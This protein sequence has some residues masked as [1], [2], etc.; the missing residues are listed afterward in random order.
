MRRMLAVVGVSLLCAS[1]F[2][3]LA[4]GLG[5]ITLHSALNQKLDAEIELIETGGLDPSEVMASLASAEDFNRVGVERFFYLTSLR[6][7]VTSRGGRMFIRVTSAQPVTEPYLNFL[8]QLLW[9][10]GRLLKEYTLLLDPPAFAEQSVAPAIAPPSRGDPGG[11]PAGRVERRPTRPDSQVSLAPSS[12]SRQAPENRLRDGSYGMT[13]R[14]DTLWT[15][16]LKT[17]PSS[18]VS[19]QQQMLA[20]QRANPEAFIGGNIN[21]LKAGFTLRLPSEEEAVAVTVADANAEVAE[22]TRQWQAFRSGEPLPT[23][24]GLGGASSMDRASAE[25]PQLAQQVDATTSSSTPAANTTGPDGELRIVAS[26]GGT[27]IGSG[28]DS[29]TEAGDVEGKLVASEEERDRIARENDELVY[30]VDRL[31]GDLEQAQRQVEVRDQQIAQLQQRLGELE[32][33]AGAQPAAAPAAKPTQLADWL[34]SPIVLIGVLVVVVGGI[35]WALIAARTRRARES[36]TADDVMPASRQTRVR[37]GR[38]TPIAPVAD[39]VADDPAEAP[40]E[41]VAEMTPNE[42]PADDEVVPGAQTS[43]VIGEAEI[44]IAYGRFPQAIGLLLAALDD[45]PGRSDVR[46]KLLELYTETRDEEGFALQ[47]AELV[48]RTDDD[49]V[50][51]E[52][53][54]LEAK[55]RDEDSARER[56]TPTADGAASEDTRGLDEFSLDLEDEPAAPREPTPRP[57]ANA[58]GGAG[59]ELGGDLGIDFDPDREPTM[60]R[61][62]RGNRPGRSAREDGADTAVEFDLE[63]LEL[64]SGGPA[65]T[66]DASKDESDDAFDFLDEEDAASTKLDLARAYIEMGDQDGARDILSEVL[67]EGTSEQQQAANELLEKLG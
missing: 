20:L 31:N 15:I 2:P 50:L 3:A 18:R 21:L 55:L 59:D 47:M 67:Q 56:S 52:A 54:A 33:Q 1:A 10:N 64:E 24:A 4:V 57:S 62:S 13:D 29:A 17:R 14:D 16:A 30:K 34:Q 49:A 19:V 66:T 32:K 60:L 41:P 22:H 38:A 43:D 65:T 63:D 11:G 27:G 5:E 6:F 28:G 48:E 61:A 26:E 25:E 12:D 46:L 40:S 44:Y 58:A 42:A 51:L 45:D 37:G 36:S 7:A 35:V 8:V 9:P 53:R 23:V 39:S